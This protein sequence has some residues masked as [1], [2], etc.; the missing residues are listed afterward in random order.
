MM[1]K[2][3]IQ[4]ASGAVCYVLLGVTVLVLALFIMGGETPLE[5]RLVADLT[6]D[7]PR[8][9]DAL[10]VWMYV[11]L[12]LAVALTLGAMACQFLRRLAV[13]SRE[14]WRSLAG[15]GALIL[16]L[17]VSWLCGSERPLDLPGYDGG[18]NTPFWLRLADMFLYAVY[19]LLGV[20]VAL[21]VGFGVRKRWMRRGL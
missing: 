8:Y 1:R 15:V 11:L 13:S 12:G 2:F 5:E 17:G 6:K 3:R 20:G 10:L 18:E 7:E 16:L 4:N 14:V 19:V 9:T 21:V